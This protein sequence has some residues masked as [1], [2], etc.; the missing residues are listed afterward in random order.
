MP[1]K[2]AADMDETCNDPNCECQEIRR[3]LAAKREDLTTE[4]I[5]EGF[6]PAEVAAL[7]ADMEASMDRLFRDARLI[8]TKLP[9]GTI[10]IDIE[11]PPGW[12]PGG[13]DA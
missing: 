11:L 5:A 3:T 2:E 4:A 13:T 7:E 6:E 12:T 10:G 1:H 9:D 8:P